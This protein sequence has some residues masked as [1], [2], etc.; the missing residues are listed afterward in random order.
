MLC[1]CQRFFFSSYYLSL[2]APDPQLSMGELKGHTDA[3]WDLA[4]HPTSGLLLSCASDGTCRLWNHQ[5][6]NPQIKLYQVEE[7]KCKKEG[8]TITLFLP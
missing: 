2:P 8:V 7:S 6:T 3:I 5:L 1:W 4:V